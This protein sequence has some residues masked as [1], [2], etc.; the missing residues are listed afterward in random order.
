[1]IV[2]SV[3]P[4]QTTIFVAPVMVATGLGDTVIVNVSVVSQV[5]PAYV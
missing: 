1:M 3:A 4:S 5:V 2:G